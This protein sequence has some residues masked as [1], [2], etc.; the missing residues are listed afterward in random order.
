LR[1]LRPRKATPA[2][3]RRDQLRQARHD[4]PT[5]RVLLPAA[6]QV[7]VELAF[8]EDDCL[9]DAPRSFT[10]FP[11]AQAYFVYDCAFGDCDGTC[12]LGDQVFNMLHAGASRASGMRCCEGHRARR[13][14]AG[15]RCGLQV[16]Y[17]VTV[18]YQAQRAA[19]DPQ[20]THA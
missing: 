10:V 12:D 16:T 13:D 20:L 9:A 7:C 11:P 3:V 5:L 17:T 8:E 6:A 2:E 19:A 4:A 18:C 14:G 15:P 1:L